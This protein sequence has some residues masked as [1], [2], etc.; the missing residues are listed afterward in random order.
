MVSATLVSGIRT[1]WRMPGVRDAVLAVVVFVSAASMPTRGGPRSAEMY[2]VMLVLLA[3]SCG[4][5]AVRRYA[6]M[7]VW[8]FCLAISVV[9][10]LTVTPDSPN[11]VPA[12]VALYG[13]AAAG[14]RWRAV[15]AGVGNT[16]ITLGAIAAHHG[17]FTDRDGAY[18]IATT[19]GLAV[20]AGVAV[21]A[22][23]AV[24]EA[25]QERAR[26]AEESREQEAQRRVVDERV[27][28]ARELHDVVAHHVA[29][30]AVHSGVAL[31]VLD[32]SPAD[33]RRSVTEVRK[34]SGQ[35]L[36]ELHTLLGLLRTSEDV[37]LVQ[38]APGMDQLPGMIA[39]MRAAGLDV[40][41]TT[42]GKPAELDPITELT[43]FRLVQESLT[44]AMKYGDGQADLSMRFVPG[45]VDIEVR[46]RVAPG[47]H[48]DGAGAG[49]GL[50]GMRERVA[51][52]GG[53]L[54]T[55]PSAD[56]VFVVR[57]LL[58]ADQVSTG[59]EPV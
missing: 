24:I 30:I 25:A 12:L 40:R 23:R 51:A 57:A 58:A 2:A 46:N 28:I 35:V 50:V 33:A 29:V 54:S 37:A 39:S 5:L 55:G 31:H 45:R 6:P 48:P 49:Q 41:W 1:R 36:G 43:A 14:S 52:V 53:D 15:A 3:L 22:Q 26:R 13:V 11:R 9:D 27:R 38:P 34:A 16:V 21:R 32:T 47:V 8:G 56:G 44:N 19:S 7:A 10:L 4:A 42:R 20:A 18:L 17:V 59:Q